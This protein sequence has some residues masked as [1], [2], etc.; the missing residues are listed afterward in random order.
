L[1]SGWVAYWPNNFS[2]ICRPC[3]FDIGNYFGQS[4][5]STI[6]A[7]ISGQPLKQSVQTGMSLSQRV[8]IMQNGMTMNVTSLLLYPVVVSAVTTFTT[9]FMVK[10]A[11]PFSISKKYY[12]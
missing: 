3:N 6:G 5:G 10:L 4:I 12:P 9:P 2:S 8:F 7:L 11:I 1:C